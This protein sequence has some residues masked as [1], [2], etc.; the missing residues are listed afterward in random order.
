MQHI[1]KQSSNA[2]AQ[3][4]DH[5]HPTTPRPRPRSRRHHRR[6]RHRPHCHGTQAAEKPRTIRTETDTFAHP[7]QTQRSTTSSANSRLQSC[8]SQ[9]QPRQRIHAQRLFQSRF[10]SDGPARLQRDS[11]S[12]NKPWPAPTHP[13]REARSRP[14]RASSTK[15]ALHS[16]RASPS[17]THTSSLSSHS[18][19]LS[20]SGKGPCTQSEPRTWKDKHHE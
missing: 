19:A 20:S 1:W 12:S 3:S 7:R 11:G 18:A 14:H 6:H 16:T 10:H 5:S 9:Q 4:Q 13:S 17:Q 2:N 15:L 8:S